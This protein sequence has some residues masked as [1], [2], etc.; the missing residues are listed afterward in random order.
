MIRC[1]G[2]DFWAWIYVRQLYYR[3]GK[4]KTA[5]HCCNY[6]GLC[7]GIC[8]GSGVSLCFECVYLE[9]SAPGSVIRDHPDH[10]TVYEKKRWCLSLP[11]VDSLVTLMFYWWTRWSQIIDP[12]SDHPNGT[13]PLMF[14]S[15]EMCY[16]VLYL[17]YEY[18]F[19]WFYF[20]SHCKVS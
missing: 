9:W 7:A 1:C 11:R 8:M 3:T 16:I 2:P 18:W 13:H 4:K 15:L 17:S 6:P 12:D 5:V 14:L 20:F 10:S 19:E